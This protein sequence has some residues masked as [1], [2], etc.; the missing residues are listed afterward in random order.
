MNKKR[1]KFDEKV[2]DKFNNDKINE[3]FES[4]TDEELKIASIELHLFEIAAILEDIM[5][6]LQQLKHP[7]K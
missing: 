5:N 7:I 4:I 1:K 3:A 2:N 6:E